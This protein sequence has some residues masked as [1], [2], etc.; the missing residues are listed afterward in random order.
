MFKIGLELEFYLTKEQK[1]ISDDSIIDL[2][3]KNLTIKLQENDVKIIEVKKEQGIGQ[4]EVTTIAKTN[5]KNII[6]DGNL[7]KKYSKD[8]ARS[9]FLEANFEARPFLDD[10]PSALQINITLLEKNN[11]LFQGNKDNESKILLNIIAAILNLSKDNLSY[12]SNKE[13]FDINY[14][15]KLFSKGK[16]TAP[17]NLSWGYDNRSCAIRITGKEENRRLEFRLCDADINIENAI[18]KLIEMAQYGILNKENPLKP[19]Y[20]NAFDDNIILNS[21][22]IKL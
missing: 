5:I 8:V 7:I 18:N 4:I 14:N 21:K 1:K 15:K 2:F 22:V 17:V 6:N 11:N 9:L 20:G 19:I 16:Y 10:C 12:F 13:R 3:I